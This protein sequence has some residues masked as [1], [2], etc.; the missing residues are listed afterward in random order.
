[1]TELLGV[2]KLMDDDV[3]SKLGTQVDDAVVEI[4]I[5]GARA[6]SPTRSLVADSDSPVR[7]RVAKRGVSGGK[8]CQPLMDTPA[9]IFPVSNIVATGH[10][11]TISV[12]V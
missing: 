7:E 9:G 1:M 2:T 11:F 10:I 3:I 8:I 6:G 4:E 5:A 12:G